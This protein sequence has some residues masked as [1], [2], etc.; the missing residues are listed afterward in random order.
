VRVLLDTH[1]LV[2][3]VDGSNRA[4][5]L[6]W[7]SACCCIRIAAS[8][9][10]DPFDRMIAQHARSRDLARFFRGRVFET[11]GVA[12]AWV[13]LGQ[14]PRELGAACSSKRRNDG[15]ASTPAAEAASSPDA[16]KAQRYDVHCASAGMT[17]VPA[18]APSI[19]TRL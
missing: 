16:T 8:P 3:L 17:T 10:C 5:Q 12:V 18:V 15:K 2:W 1:P 14:K 4:H 11:F 13:Q 9:H 6:R 19:P 7:P